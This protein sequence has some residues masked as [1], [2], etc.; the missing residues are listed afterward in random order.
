MKRAYAQ[1][2]FVIGCLLLLL[3]SFSLSAQVEN[4]VVQVKKE[5]QPVADQGNGY[6]LN[7]IIPGNY[8]D[9]S[10][11]RVDQDYYMAFSRGNGFIIWHSRDLV[12]WKPVVR[13][14]LPDGYN[15]I[16]AVDLQYYDG[17]FHLYMPI[18]TYPGK[19]K[20]AFG[21]FVVT[22][23]NID[24][25]WSDPVN[26]EI[27]DANDSYWSAID[28]GFIQ[29]PEGE[30]YLYVNHG[31]VVKLNDAGD[32]AVTP[33][34]LVYEGWQY[35][36]DWNVECMCLESPKLFYKDGFYYLVS[37]EGGTSGP[38]TAHMSIVARS[39]SPTGSWVNSP[40]NP[41]VHT[42]TQN[43]KWWQQGH[44][45]IF[46][47]T[48][49]SWWTVYHARLNNF[50]ELGRST[51]L[52]PVEW[53]TDGWPVI[54][55]GHRASDLIPLP[56][57]E[58]IGGG[59]ALSDN[60]ESNKPGIQW[61][62]SHEM[63]QHVTCGNGE[64]ILKAQGS[65]VNDAANITVGAVNKSFEV[66]VE[67]DCPNPQITTGISLGTDG[68]Q[69]DG[70]SSTFSDAPDWRLNGAQI[71]VRNKGHVYLRIKNF[72]KD[73]SFFVSDDGTNWKSFGKGLRVN[74]SYT[75]RLFAFGD[76]KAS[77]KNFK[78]IGLE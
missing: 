77:F 17:K 71:P 1:N 75:I 64:L 50:P 48:D 3:W 62:I 47:A 29:T 31:Y 4:Q 51:L 44:G 41:L 72:R 53:T 24:G 43:E 20:A 25:S 76:G 45:T 26:L 6:Y 37:A 19:D 33:P 21:N 14:Y 8:G 54:K 12:N 52:M 34:K 42:Y 15:T 28:P 10:I 2:Q 39:K 70:I 27:S 60:F 16:W 69:T 78:Y 32:K 13:H 56:S 38:S 68:V 7:P 65:S 74:G 61:N 66:V 9:P 5:N 30:K 57:G 58:N 55:S 36:T 73:L 22:A 35:P 18:R 46:E 67:V 40:Y 59:L 23:K 49:G 11:V 63:K